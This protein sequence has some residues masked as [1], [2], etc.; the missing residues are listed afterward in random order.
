MKVYVQFFH[1]SH[2]YDGNHPEHL[3]EA[4]GDSGVFILDG[5]N[6]LDT[7]KQDAENR[8]KQLCTWKKYTKYEIRRGDF[9]NYAV[10]YRNF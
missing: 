2:N 3:I 10:I 1:M 4:C 6:S 9:R 5:R 8:V 7:W